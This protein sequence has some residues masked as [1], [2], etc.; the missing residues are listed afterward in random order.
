MIFA[1]LP[2]ESKWMSGFGDGDDIGIVWSIEEQIDHM[3]QYPYSSDYCEP[4]W[5]VMRRYPAVTL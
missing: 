5:Q 2:I 1:Y 4:L 3:N